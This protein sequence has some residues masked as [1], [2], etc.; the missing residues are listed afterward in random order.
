MARN[1]VNEILS[2]RERFIKHL[3]DDLVKNDKI[4]E[5]AAASISDLKITSTNVEI[6]GK[7]VE[8]TS[9][10][11][12]GKNIYVNGVI[13]HTGEYFIDKVAFP[14]SYSVLETL[15]GT[16]QLLENKIKKQSKLLKESENAKA[17]IEE[18]IKLLKGEKE[19]EEND[20]PK[21]IVSDKGIAVKV[22]Q[23]YEIVEFEN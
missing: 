14:E 17:Q 13:K 5:E 16:L 2:S 19:E 20:L 1:F 23:L 12:L 18:R 22:G 3:S 8:H 6:L 21:E 11:P 7:K 4:I 15:D 10:I 9:L